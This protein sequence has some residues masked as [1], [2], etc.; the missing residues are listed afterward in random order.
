MADIVLVEDK[1]RQLDPSTFQRLCDNVM[2]YR[3][4]KN[5]NSLGNMPGKRK[6]R[7]GT[8]DSFWFNEITKT[9][10]FCEYTMAIDGIAKKFSKDVQRCLNEAQKVGVAISEIVFIHSTNDLKLED[11]KAIRDYCYRKSI[12]LTTIG[13]TELAHIINKN[14]YLLNSFFSIDETNRS[15]ITL[16]EFVSENSNHASD[17]M[18]YSFVG[19]DKEV[20]EIIT[21]INNNKYV[22]VSGESGCG[23]SRLVVEALQRIDR[24]V[25]CIDRHYAKAINNLLDELNEDEEMVVFIDDINQLNYVNEMVAALEKK[26]YR[27]IKLVGTVRNYALHNITSVFGDN[28]FCVVQIGVMSNDEIKEVLKINLN[29]INNKF[30]DRIIEIANGNVRIAILAG[31]ESLKSGLAFLYRSESLLSTYYKKRIAQQFGGNYSN[32]IKVLFFVTFLNKIDLANLDRHKSLLDFIGINNEDVKEKSHDL[33]RLE[34]FK[35]IS[36]RVVSIDDQCLSNYVIYDSFVDGKIVVLGEFIKNLFKDYGS[37]IVDS[38]NMIGRVYTSKESFDYVQSEVVGIWNHFKKVGG[39]IYDDFVS[40]FAALNKEEAIC[41]SKQMLFDSKKYQHMTKHEKFEKPSYG[42]N[43]YISILESIESPAAIHYLF[44]ALGYSSIRNDAYSA[45]ERILTIEVDDFAQSFERFDS[46]IK[47]TKNLSGPLLYDILN[48]LSSKILDFNFSYSSYKKKNQFVHYSFNLKDEYIAIIP[49]RHTIWEL[50]LLLSDEQ[51]YKFV[52]DYLKYY[53]S[54]ESKEIF[55]HDLADASRVLESIENRQKLQEIDICLRSKKHLKE[56]GVLWSPFKSKYN[57]EVSFLTNALRMKKDKY[58]YSDDEYSA[59]LNN[60]VLNCSKSSFAR[61]VRL[62]A[63]FKKIDSGRAYK[64]SDFLGIVIGKMDKDRLLPFSNIILSYDSLVSN[65]VLSAIASRIIDLMDK[66]Y[67]TTKT[68]I[69]NRSDELLLYF[70]SNYVEK[71][72]ND[73]RIKELFTTF[74]EEKINQNC[75]CFDSVRPNVIWSL[76]DNK[77][78]V[79]LVSHI[80]NYTKKTKKVLPWTLELL[81]NPYSKPKTTDVFKT[82]IDANSLDTLFDVFE[83]GLLKGNDPYNASDYTFVFA[84]YNI[85]YLKRLAQIESKEERHYECYTFKGL[86]NQANCK[87]YACLIFN[88]FIK[89][90]KYYSFFAHQLKHILDLDGHND[91]YPDS[92]FDTAIELYRRYINNKKALN[93]IGALVNETSES[94]RIDYLM[95]LIQNGFLSVQEFS[96]YNFFSSMESFSDSYVPIINDK[97]HFFEKM[98]DRLNEDP[99]LIEYSRCVSYK[100]NSFIKYKEEVK[101]KETVEGLF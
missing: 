82:F 29:I 66:P 40:K 61:D 52:A 99:E 86:W 9:Y 53:P 87:E 47:E 37:L 80:F 27:K 55:K 54:K 49:L 77:H 63:D 76:L 88:E 18:S 35:I 69:C 83:Y 22:F 72:Q 93:L 19:R 17:N 74:V 30:L 4:A 58:E 8:P 42:G 90:K 43:Q 100:I 50:A 11:D 41:H 64:I 7:K 96:D 24:R 5:L 56:T 59:S 2:F 51:K 44:K 12:Q 6:T 46:I 20:N 14:K 23:K 98:R 26:R 38:L 97:I 70:F 92:F 25:L 21:A 79:A 28:Q 94:I 13:L 85:D 73:G 84:D 95:A 71:K 39:A 75:E 81:F 78:I 48:L 62:L 65:M 31:E 1:I 32:Y 60:Y 91:A 3:G 16:G 89:T 10:V 68:I 36:N 34:I 45:L 101:I 15:I 67:E 57:K 33:E